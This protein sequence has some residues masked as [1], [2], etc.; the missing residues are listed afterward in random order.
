MRIIVDLPDYDGNALDVIWDEGA[1][2]TLDFDG[3]GLI[4]SA[5]KSGLISLA[6][7]ML[8]MAHSNL[9]F[10]SHVHYSSFFT[11][12]GEETLEITICKD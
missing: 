2:Y 11:K 12:M 7:Q 4:I 3:N 8:Y 6:K 5:N 1:N 9:P 10:G